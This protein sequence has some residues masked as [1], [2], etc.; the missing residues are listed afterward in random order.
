MEVL[1]GRNFGSLLED[2]PGTVDGRAWYR[3]KALGEICRT[4]YGTFGSKVGKG[5]KKGKKCKN[6]PWG[7]LW[8][9]GSPEK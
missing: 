6:L 7:S 4:V 2:L 5:F 8:F 1:Q 9:F 3:W